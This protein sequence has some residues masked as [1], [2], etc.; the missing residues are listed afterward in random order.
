MSAATAPTSVTLGKSSPLAIICVPIMTLA[1]PLRKRS[2]SFSCASFSR[3]V[4][5]STRTVRASGNSR[6]TSSST[7]CV[8]APKYLM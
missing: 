7:F 4:S 5:L 1:A 8:P 3:V 6:R 2:S